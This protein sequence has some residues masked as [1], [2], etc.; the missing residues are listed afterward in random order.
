[1]HQNE[2]WDEILKILKKYGFVTV[3]Y[4]IETLHYSNATINRDLNVLEQQ[5]LLKRCYGGA[6]PTN[7]VKTGTPL[8]F[9]YKKMHTEKL[10]IGELAAS[11]VNDYDF[12]F[13]DGSTT[14][15]HMAKFLTEKKHITV[16]TNNLAIVSFLSEFGVRAI[17]LGGVVKEPPSMLCNA[18]TV[19]NASRFKYDKMFFSTGLFTEDGRIYAGEAYYLLYKTVAQNASEVYY[20]ADHSKI[21]APSV[22][23]QLLFDLHSISGIISDYAFNVET[24]QKFPHT[25]FI[26]LKN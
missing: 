7:G 21:E 11:L 15:E 3:K 16:V 24:Q 4:L 6:E 10:R 5:G 19:E 23:R 17:C 1:M 20:L 26:H 2:R 9:R 18:M 8:P 22:H 13:V 25:K 14:C 12:I